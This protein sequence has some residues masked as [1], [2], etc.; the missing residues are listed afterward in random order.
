ME[1]KQGVLQE[2]LRQ[3]EQSVSVIEAADQITRVYDF[4]V[5][6]YFVWMRDPATTL[7][8]FRASQQPYRYYVEH[9]SRPL[10]AVLAR[11]GPAATLV[12]GAVLTGPDPEFDRTRTAGITP[13]PLNLP[14]ERLMDILSRT[15]GPPDS[16]RRGPRRERDDRRPAP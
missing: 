5:H 15:D 6:P 3:A 14:A 10:A 8:A 16:D 7:E 13:E 4:Y 12:D 9:F 2:A 1:W 11:I